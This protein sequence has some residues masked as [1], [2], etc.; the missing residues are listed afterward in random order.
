MRCGFCKPSKSSLVT[1]L[2][3]LEELARQPRPQEAGDAAQRHAT[4]RDMQEPAAA[5]ACLMLAAGRLLH[6]KG[7]AILQYTTPERYQ[8][9]ALPSLLQ[10]VIVAACAT[11]TKEPGAVQGLHC[12]G[13]A[14]V[15]LRR[16]LCAFLYLTANEQSKHRFHGAGGGQ[17]G[18]I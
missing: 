12:L 8:L 2:Q 1:A 16:A 18:H 11:H 5:C 9:E 13:A 14:P 7:R 6:C 4:P 3:L 15:S 17:C 10:Q